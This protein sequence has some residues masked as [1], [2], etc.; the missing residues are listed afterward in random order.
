MDIIAAR[1][2]LHQIPEI[3]FGENATKALLLQYLEDIIYSPD[4]WKI[5]EFKDSTGIL[6]AYTAGEGGYRLFRADMD[7][8]PIAENSGCSF[9]SQNKGFM[10]ACGHDVHLAVL[11]GLIQ[12]IERFKPAKNLLFLFQPAEEGSGGAQS[13]LSEGIIKSYPVD[14]AIALHVASEMQVGTVA[15]KAGIFFGIP[16]EFNVRFHGKAAHVAYPEKGINALSAGVD[17]MHSMQAPI[18]DLSKTERVIFHIGKMSA[19]IIRNVIADTCILEGTHRSLR[20]EVCSTINK[21]IEEQAN[22]AAQSIGAEFDVELLCSYDPVVNG[23]TLVE[24]FMHVCSQAGVIYQEAETAM[25]GEDFGFFTTL[26]PGLLFWLG[27]GCDHPLHSDK[28]LPQD[29]CIA[30]GIKLMLGLAV[31]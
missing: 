9:S 29:E 5:H 23:G 18:A 2:A 11:L 3:A 20:R 15:S 7:A 21:L 4:N 13:V 30:V 14:S 12:E 17:F 19:G 10:H 25:T 26:Y 24:E 22:L 28:F 8:L 16:Q 1:H 31:N 6:L 27:S